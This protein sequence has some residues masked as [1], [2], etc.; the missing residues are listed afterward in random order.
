MKTDGSTPSVFICTMKAL[1]LFLSFTILLLSGS[2]PAGNV[3]MVKI[4][5]GTYT[6][7][8]KLPGT[9][10]L[11]LRPYLMDETAVTNRQFLDF[12]K[13]NPKWQRSK[14]S[15]LF[16]DTN[17]LKYW[18]SDLVIGEKNKGLYNSPVVNISWFAAKA[19]AEWQGKRLPTVAEWEHA[20]QAPPAGGTEEKLTQYILGWYQKPNPKVLPNVRSTFKNTYGL[21]DMHG[22]IWEWTFDFNSFIKSGDSRANTEDEL[23]LFCASS[24]LYV[25]NKEDYASFLRYSYRGSLKGNFCIANLGFRCV[26]DL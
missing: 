16:A 1:I 18:E 6:P 20:G 26:K 4:S 23:K 8:F 24:S 7:F 15:R 9:P 14:V 5:G 2:L 22:L 3:K 12:V 10:P 21:Y 11:H 19:Y 13:A 25:D 17:Y